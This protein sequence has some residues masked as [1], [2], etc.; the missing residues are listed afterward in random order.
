M[1][2]RYIPLFVASLVAQASAQCIAAT[3]SSLEFSD[4]SYSVGSIVDDQA[5]CLTQ[6]AGSYTFS[7]MTMLTT[8]G[9]TFGG[10]GLYASGT[11]F[12]IFDQD[13]RI[14]AIHKKPNCGIPYYFEDSFMPYAGIIDRI[15][16]DVGNPF[17]NF[18]YGNGDYLINENG[19]VCNDMSSIFITAI[20]GCRCAFPISGVA[21]N[22]RA[23]A[24]E[25]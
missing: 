21:A 10:A 2:F 22:K 17:F 3:A 15:S 1:L 4:Q 16:M 7:M 9:I 18:K 5:L 25:G 12:L 19:C 8:N 13:C 6:G 14:A 23:I 24:F 20:K 11:A